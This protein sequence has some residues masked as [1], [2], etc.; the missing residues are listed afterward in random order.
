MCQK[1]K[2]VGVA[3]FVSE[4]KPLETYTEFEKLSK[5][6]MVYRVCNLKYR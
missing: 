5:F 6:S 4:I 1:Y 3:D 2:K